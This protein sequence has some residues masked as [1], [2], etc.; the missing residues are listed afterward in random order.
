M[1]TNPTKSIAVYFFLSLFQTY[2][3][4]DNLYLYMLNGRT[5]SGTLVFNYQKEVLYLIKCHPNILES[6]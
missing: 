1:Q 2:R 3:L 6:S 5:N 4:S